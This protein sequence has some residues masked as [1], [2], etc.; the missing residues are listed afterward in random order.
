MSVTLLQLVVAFAPEPQF[1]EQCTSFFSTGLAPPVCASIDPS[2]SDQVRLIESAAFVL[3]TATAHRV[4]Q[5]ER[6]WC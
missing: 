2:I 6:N 4:Y 1:P 5:S 3:L